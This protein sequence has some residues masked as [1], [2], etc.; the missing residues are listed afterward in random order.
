MIVMGHLAR[1]GMNKAAE[2]VNIEILTARA[3]SARV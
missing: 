1:A 2:T 3:T